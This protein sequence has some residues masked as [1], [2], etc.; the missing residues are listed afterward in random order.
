MAQ[1]TDKTKN[2]IKI[3]E[4]LYVRYDRDYLDNLQIQNPTL[5]Q[6]LNFYLDNAWYITDY[7]KEKTPLTYPTVTIS[8]LAN[9]NILRLEN[10]QDLQRDFKKQMVY[11]IT[12][13]DKVL[14]YYSGKK[15]VEK[16]NSARM[17]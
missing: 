1:T 17:K 15:F 5:L 13:T 7:P 3:D 10:D 11:Q 4:R 16:F 14:V 8:D 9:V 6:R 12:G 2:T